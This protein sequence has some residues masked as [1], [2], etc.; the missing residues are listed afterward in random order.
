MVVSVI[1]KPCLVA[2]TACLNY[3]CFM[4]RFFRGLGW[5]HYLKVLGFQCDNP[6]RLLAS[7]QRVWPYGRIGLERWLATLTRLY[8]NP[9]SNTSEVAGAARYIGGSSAGLCKAQRI[10]SSLGADWLSC[11]FLAWW[12]WQVSR[13][14]CLVRA[15]VCLWTDY[16]ICNVEHWSGPVL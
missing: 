15:I 5:S 12:E 3:F 4:W 1:C 10:D 9:G 7:H 8:I 2:G 6:A 14:G 11:F 16:I 13:Q